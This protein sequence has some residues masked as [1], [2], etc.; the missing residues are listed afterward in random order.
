MHKLDEK[1]KKC[2]KE[3]ENA[4]FLKLMKSKVYKYQIINSINIHP[5]D[6]RW[7]PDDCLFNSLTYFSG[8]LK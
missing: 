8:G 6:L 2:F 5:G 7:L 1:L 3:G 4:L